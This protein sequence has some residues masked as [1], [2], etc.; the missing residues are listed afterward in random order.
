MK[1]LE[2]IG[3]LLRSAHLDPSLLAPEAMRSIVDERRRATGTGSLDAYADLASR[4]SDEFARLREQIAVPETWLFRYAESFELLHR[5]LA[6]RGP[7][8]FRAL[9][10]ACATGAEAFSIAAT[11]L[12]AGIPP[13]DIHVLAIDPNPAALQRARNADLGRMAVRHG[14]PGWSAGLIDARAGSATVSQAVRARV[15]FREGSAPEALADLPARSYDAVFC[16]N[17]AIYLSGAGRRSIGAAID[18]LLAEDGILF[19]GHAERPALFGLEDAFA[20]A[21]PDSP[22]TF[23]SVRRTTPGT[24]TE[25]RP[26]VTAVE[27]LARRGS[28][29]PTEQTANGIAGAARRASAPPRDPAA[30]PAVAPGSREARTLAQARAAADAGDLRQAAQIIERLHADGDR[31]I[32]LSELRGSVALARGEDALAERSW[33]EVLYLDPGH[34]EALLQLAVLADRRG[35]PDLAAR[36]RLRASKGDRP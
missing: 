15:E 21:D 4:S 24:V 26:W 11:A 36:Y 3:D 1:A 31:S 12:A 7:A 5:R 14:V 8:P 29:L 33:R 19:L 22:G 28:G 23:A 25:P 10:I 17:L 34:V 2:R 13:A 9:S 16:R 18:R 30:R 27:E 32:A 6:A 35:D 20:P